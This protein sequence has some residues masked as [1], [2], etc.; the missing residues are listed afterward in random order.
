MM[1][2]KE[3]KRLSKAAWNK[4]GNLQFIMLMEEPAELIQ[5]VSKYLRNKNADT[6]KHLCEE[7]ADTEIM[8][9]QYRDLSPEMND[10]IDRYKEE[11]LK[12]LKKILEGK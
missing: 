3:R 12:R 6:V 10:M 7:I 9:E 4:W 1:D 8:C 5:A 11:K 2:L